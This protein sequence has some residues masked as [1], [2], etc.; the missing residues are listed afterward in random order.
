M[1]P[2]IMLSQVLLLLSIAMP[3]ARPAAP[4]GDLFDQLFQRGLIRQKSMK[5]IRATFTETTV[6]T[7]LVKPIVARGTIVAAPP[8]RVRM[9][10]TEPDPKLVVMDAGKLTVVWPRRSEREQIDIRETQKR[11]DQYFT[12][13]SVEDLRKLFDIKAVPDP[14]MRSADRIEMTPKRKQIKQGLEKLELWID[15]EKEV[16][17]QMRMAFP[18]GDQKTIALDDIMLNVPLGDDTFQ[19]KP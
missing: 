12:K 18:G 8:A 14:V 2:V 4:S 3:Q 5:S 17:V 10:Y 16:L 7:L 15:R 9:T 6:S 11:I 13:A 1:S 19:A